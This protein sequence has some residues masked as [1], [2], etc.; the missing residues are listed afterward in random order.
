MPLRIGILS[1]W[2]TRCGIAE[3]S[4]HLVAAL[5]QQGD[6][7]VIVLSSRNFGERAVAPYEEWVEPTFDVQVWHPRHKF[8]LDV[9][10]ILEHDLDVLHVQ[11]SNLFYDRGRLI[12]LLRRFRGVTA[13]TYHDKAVGVGFPYDLLDLLYAH[14]PDVGTGPRRLI[15]QG[16]DL[17]RPVVKT[18]GLGKS[19][20]DV[21][22]AVCERNDWEF[23]R[24][25]GEDRWLDSEEL[26]GWLRDS[27]AIVLWYDDDPRSGGSAGAPLAIGTRRPVFVNDTEWFRDLP[28]Q[29]TNLH[30]V[31]TPE[32]LEE[33]LHA[34]LS[35]PYAEGR[36]WDRV[37]CTL[38]A[39]F[40]NALERE[41]ARL[42]RRGDPLRGK[43]FVTLDHKPLRRVLRQARS[44]AAGV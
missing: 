14:R 3:Y 8:D 31:H 6:V 28:E 29:A 27:D 34:V 23:L 41:P 1:T 11:Y 25:F 12:E 9:E 36:T 44:L 2:N 13:L 38:L 32:E 5:R 39:D 30:K 33:G 40:R 18:F 20:V 4:R 22:A 16:I 24:S 37:A 17:R 7:E 43:V 26:F 35:N 10:A 19:R 15:P 42:P 21:I